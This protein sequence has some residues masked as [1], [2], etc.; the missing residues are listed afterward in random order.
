[1]TVAAIDFL[2]DQTVKQVSSMSSESAVVIPKWAWFLLLTT[3][4]GGGSWMTWASVHLAS[5][6]SALEHSAENAKAIRVIREEQIRQ[7]NSN[8][9]V[10]AMD[11]SIVKLE[12]QV[13]FLREKLLDQERL[14]KKI[15]G[16]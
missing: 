4:I 9:D 1:M 14:L 6:P 13:E 15:N 7:S 2:L 3:V 5:V 11:R 12:I 8:Y 10:H 16:Q